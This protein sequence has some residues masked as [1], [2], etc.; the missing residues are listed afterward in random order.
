ISLAR[1]RQHVKPLAA[2]AWLARLGRH[3]EPTKAASASRTADAR[4]LAN[5]A[6]DGG[7]VRGRCRLRWYPRPLSQE[8]VGLFVPGPCPWG[9][10]RAG[11]W[12][13]AVLDA[14]SVRAQQGRGAPATLPGHNPRY[15]AQWSDRGR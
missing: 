2:R 4:R 5:E 12:Q 14:E 11:P 15:C 3:D 10:V 6:Q 9:A 8:Q 13:A 1:A 7:V